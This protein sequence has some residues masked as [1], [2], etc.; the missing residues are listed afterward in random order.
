MLR[1]FK[2]SCYVLVILGLSACSRIIGENGYVHTQKYAYLNAHNGPIVTVPADMSSESFS[3]HY[4]IPDV[5]GDP[6]I[7]ILPPG[8]LAAMEQHSHE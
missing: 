6:R 1:F 4:I 8:S 2:F 5:Q 3:K 7:S